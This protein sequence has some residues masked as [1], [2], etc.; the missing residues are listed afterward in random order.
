[1]AKQEVGRLVEALARDPEL[2]A[3]LEQSTTEDEMIATAR[4]AGYTFTVA[5][6]REAVQARM[7]ELTEAQ[8]ER[9][10]GGAHPGGVNVAL[11]DGSVRVLS[12]S[13][14]LKILTGL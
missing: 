4:A 5:E 1:M 7:R 12:S 6:L 10:A 13:I 2:R 11:G 14:Q 8:L 3:K 9:V